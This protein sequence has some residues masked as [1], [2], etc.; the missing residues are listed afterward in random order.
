MD[1]SCKKMVAYQSPHRGQ[2]EGP[3]LNSKEVRFLNMVSAQSPFPRQ[4][5]DLG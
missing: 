1:A 3:A 2:A 4:H 5:L